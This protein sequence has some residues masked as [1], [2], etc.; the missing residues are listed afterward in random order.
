MILKANNLLVNV[1]H[2]KAIAYEW[3][4]SPFQSGIENGVAVSGYINLPALFIVSL[5]SLLLI[6]GT[7]ESAFVNGIIV[8]TKVAIVILIIIL[9]WGFVGTECG[10]RWEP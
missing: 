3:C 4:H 1:L 7:Q 9:G 6:R 2:T 8:I 5:L 10:L